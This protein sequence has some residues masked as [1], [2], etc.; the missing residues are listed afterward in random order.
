MKWWHWIV[1][2]FLPVILLI[3]LIST[4]VK[5]AGPGG[6]TPGPQGTS[7]TISTPFGTVNISGL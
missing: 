3:W 5:G 7:G 2:V 6:P 4:L 1:F